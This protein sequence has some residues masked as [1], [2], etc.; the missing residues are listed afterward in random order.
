MPTAKDLMTR[1][2][3]CCRASD[4]IVDAV[5]IMQDKN[6][7]VVPI[8]E[9]N[10]RCVGIVTDRDLC[11]DV[12]LKRLDPA[13]TTLSE[14]MHTHLLTCAEDEDVESILRKMQQRQVKRIVVVDRADQCIGIISEHDFAAAHMRPEKLGQFVEKVFG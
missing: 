4:K 1:N 13:R 9:D 14:V 2:P 6:V 7:G 3:S 11:L 5:Q 12:I 10:G 8:C